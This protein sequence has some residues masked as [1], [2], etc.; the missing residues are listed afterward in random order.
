MNQTDL[1]IRGHRALSQ[2]EVDLMNRIKAKSREMLELHEELVASL[3]TH[4]IALRNAIDNSPLGVSAAAASG[5]LD[6]YR[7]A[8][9]LRW[10][11]I[12]KTDIQTGTMAMIRAI[13]QS[14]EG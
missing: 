12:G 14:S 6:R 9:P 4:E 5:E 2:A 13:A 8:E 3:K 1:R 11:S 7:A 10:A